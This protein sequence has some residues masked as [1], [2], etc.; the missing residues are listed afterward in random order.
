MQSKSSHFTVPTTSAKNSTDEFRRSKYPMGHYRSNDER[1]RSPASGH[2]VSRHK[3]RMQAQA[4]QAS[5]EPTDGDSDESAE[6]EGDD[7][8][9]VLLTLTCTEPRE[10]FPKSLC[11]F[12][13]GKLN[14]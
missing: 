2:R 14:T 8:D 4:R 9:K 3:P 10:Q 1:F 13:F 7:E 5:S 6:A 12:S 11:R